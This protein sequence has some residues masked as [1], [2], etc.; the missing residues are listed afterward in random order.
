MTTPR[1]LTIAGSDS[2]GGAGIQADLKTFHQL[3]V[4]GMSALTAV[5]AQNTLGVTDIYELEAEAVARQID[6]VA[7][8]IGM[9]ALKTGMISSTPIMEVIAE[10]IRQYH[11]SPLVVDPVMV[12]KSGHSL[13][14]ESARKSLIHTLLPLACLVTPNLPEAEILVGKKLDTEIKRKEAARRI[15][16]MGVSAVVIKGGHLDGDQAT[17]L[18]FDGEQFLAFSAPR[19]A[20]HHTHGTGCTFSAAATAALAKGESVTEAV[21]TAK[22]FI[23]QGI[24]HSLGLGKGYG[25]TNHWAYR[26]HSD[27]VISKTPST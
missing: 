21:Y 2:G 26:K 7:E 3:H 15:V 9:D 18:F 23:T 14:E 17:D 24:A 8:D 20:T 10:K 25:P 12:S 19:I 22:T 1:A 4:Y 13:L 5:T 27:C 11:L 16:D 6:A